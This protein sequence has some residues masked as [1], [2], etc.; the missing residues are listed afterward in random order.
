MTRAVFFDRD[1]TLMEDQ[2]HAARPEAVKLLPGVPEAL[3]R[4]SRGGFRLAV[5]TNQSGVARG[6]TDEA[7]VR[8]VNERLREMLAPAARIERFFVCPHLAEGIVPEYALDC[9]CR[10][11][12]PGLILRALRELGAD[13]ARS[14]T[15]GDSTRDVQAGR[16]A[17]TRSVLVQTGV[18]AAAGTVPEADHVAPDLGHAALWILE[19][20]GVERRG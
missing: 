2:G 17:G 11:P 3:Q 6:L 8:A 15:V 16:A 1:G 14:F 9:D 19:Q 5:V 10:K 7:T 12:R 13:P 20:A 4:I 18:S